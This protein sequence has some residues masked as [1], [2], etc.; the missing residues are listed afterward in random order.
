MGKLSRKPRH[1][2]G[3]PVRDHEEDER[4]G[5]VDICSVD[6]VESAPF[7]LDNVMFSQGLETSITNDF[8]RFFGVGVDKVFQLVIF[9]ELLFRDQV[10]K[11]GKDN[12]SVVGYICQLSI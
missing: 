9:L 6:A 4:L 2:L 11:L 12:R 5:A 1:G 3:L 10:V 7:Q 8:G